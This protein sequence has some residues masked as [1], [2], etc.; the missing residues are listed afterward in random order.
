MTA[1]EQEQAVMTTAANEFPPQ[2]VSSPGTPEFAGDPELDEALTLAE[3]QR[4]C[5]VCGSRKQVL[6]GANRGI[7]GD[8]PSPVFV[9]VD[10]GL[11]NSSSAAKRILLLKP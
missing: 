8:V 2:R 1:P 11:S 7:L 4:G 9:P 3:G 6:E 10:S 5:T